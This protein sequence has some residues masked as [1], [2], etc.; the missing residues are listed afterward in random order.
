MTGGATFDSASSEGQSLE[1]NWNA[2]ST[3]E[4]DLAGHDPG[5]VPVTEVPRRGG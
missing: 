1:P 3:A 2:L 5:T 4:A